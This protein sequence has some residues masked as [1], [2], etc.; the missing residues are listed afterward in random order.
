[1]HHYGQC[2]ARQDI[3]VCRQDIA[4][5]NEQSVNNANRSLKLI[6]MDKIPLMMM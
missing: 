2:Q 6:K 4:G 5:C 1:M 3:A